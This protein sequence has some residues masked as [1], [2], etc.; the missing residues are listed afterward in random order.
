MPPQIHVVNPRRAELARLLSM[1]REPLGGVALQ[2][3]RRPCRSFRQDAGI[4]LSEPRADP[5]RRQF[6]CLLTLR[7]GSHSLTLALA[8]VMDEQPPCAL[9]L[10]DP[11]AHGELLSFGEQIVRQSRR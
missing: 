3:D 4:A 6:G 7:A 10:V 9:P 2:S 11:N 5:E 8:L 1:S